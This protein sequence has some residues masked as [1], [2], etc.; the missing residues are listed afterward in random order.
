M[1]ER[2]W[3]IHTAIEFIE[4]HL[5]EDITVADIATA[6][7]YSLY[8]FVRTFNQIVQHTPYDYL[9]RRRL[10][11]AASDLILSDHRIIDI[12]IKYQFNNHETFTRAFKRMFDIQ[13]SQFRE[14]G[15]IPN[16]NLMPA[17]THE[18]LTLINRGDFWYPVIIQRETTCLA[19]LMTQ[20]RENLFRLWKSLGQVVEGSSFPETPQ[21]YGVSHQPEF[22]DGL[23]FYL[24]GI[25]ISSPENVKPPLVTQTLPKGTYVHV[26]FKGNPGQLSLTLGYIYHTW[27][28]KS[29]YRIAHPIEVE[30]YGSTPKNEF[31][32]DLNIYIPI[33][34]FA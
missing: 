31:D 11:E 4:D 8:H 5:Q 21:F 10:S 14:G 26:I 18:Y 27:L 17:L 7:G 3:T 28:P 2:V 30:Y 9:M 29:E 32:S 19:G 34:T 24:A 25:E 16:R 23:S 12:S 20:E 15:M 13:P 1:S 6:A 33:E 22:P